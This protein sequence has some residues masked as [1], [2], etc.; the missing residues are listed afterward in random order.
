MNV[1]R[2]IPTVTSRGDMTQNEHAAEASN[3]SHSA[4]Q[5]GNIVQQTANTKNRCIQLDLTLTLPARNEFLVR[6]VP[7]NSNLSPFTPYVLFLPL[8]I[9]TTTHLL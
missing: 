2:D 6:L 1:S 5:G 9:G 4:L 7:R 8:F 3:P